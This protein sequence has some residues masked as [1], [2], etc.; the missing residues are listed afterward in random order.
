MNRGA[1]QAIVKAWWVVKSQTRLK[2]LSLCV[3][4]CAHMRVHTHTHTHTRAHSIAGEV[5][6]F[7]LVLPNV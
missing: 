2:Q 1:W 6:L 5:N 3:R 4:A 7:F